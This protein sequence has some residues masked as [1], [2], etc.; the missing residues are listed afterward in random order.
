MDNFSLVAS[1]LGLLGFVLGI[2]ALAK[3][4]RI[5]MATSL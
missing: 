2:T 4:L 5:E 1:T 3:I